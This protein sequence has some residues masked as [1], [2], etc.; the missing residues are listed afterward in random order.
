MHD[1]L[2]FIVAMMWFVLPRFQIQLTFSNG[3]YNLSSHDGS[4]QV[5]IGIILIAFVLVWL[6]ASFPSHST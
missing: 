4:L 2:L 1:C 5:C 6:E 3:I